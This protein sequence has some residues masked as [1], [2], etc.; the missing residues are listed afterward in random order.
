M[1]MVE[2]G[3]VVIAGLWFFGVVMAR[4]EEKLKL[5]SPEGKG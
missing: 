3:L 2:A 1:Y 4:Y 5:Q